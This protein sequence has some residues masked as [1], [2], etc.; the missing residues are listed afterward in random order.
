MLHGSHSVGG[1]DTVYIRQ[2]LTLLP[3]Y[4]ILCEL[5]SLEKEGGRYTVVQSTDRQKLVFPDIGSVNLF[6][7]KFC[8]DHKVDIIHIHTMYLPGVTKFCLDIRPVIKSAHSTDLVCPGSYKFFSN[9]EDICT[10]PFGAHCLVHAYTNRCCSRSPVKLAA[11]YNNV[12]SEIREFSG[13]YKS[14]VV[15]SDYVRRECIAAG[16]HAK[17][18]TVN[19]Y[20][21]IPQQPGKTDK[22][23]KRILYVGRLSQVKGVHH[24]LKAVAEILQGNDN[25]HLDIVGDGPYK[26]KLMDLA[27]NLYLNHKIIF[28]GWLD[29][30]EIN[31]MLSSCYLV[32]FPSIYPEAFGISGIEAMMHGK[33]VIG[34]DVGGV[35]S[36]LHDG[37]SGF[38]V[39][40]KDTTEFGKKVELL[41]NDEALAGRM[42]SKGHEIASGNFIPEIHIQKLVDIYKQAV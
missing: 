15:M 42:G 34:F 29:R 16:I 39:K 28:H 23:G 37:V 13:R 38:L 6:I 22:A 33:P 25:V 24:M 8:A 31:E 36:W 18:I 3:Q 5:I 26:R 30:K 4:G 20:F 11:L 7:K 40:A 41:L 12:A 17:N 9:S 27:D 19:P 10:I 35:S 14:I 2:L 1:G 21:T 32:V